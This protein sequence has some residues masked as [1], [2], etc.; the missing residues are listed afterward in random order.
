MVEIPAPLSTFRVE[1]CE[2]DR[3]AVRFAFSLDRPIDRQ[4][5]RAWGREGPASLDRRL[6]H[7]T[8]LAM[9]LLPSVM[10][11]AIDEAIPF[12]PQQRGL[13]SRPL[14][15]PITERREDRL[16]EA[17]RERRTD[18]SALNLSL[19][20]KRERER[21]ER[22]SCKGRACVRHVKRLKQRPASP[23]FLR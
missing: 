1:F 23:S 16:I 7:F 4:T 11:S 5:D 2:R 17:Q 6:S 13:R 8:V 19:F 10:P 3:I 18:G 15:S 20:Q 22:K 21:R 14:Q 12:S 9:M